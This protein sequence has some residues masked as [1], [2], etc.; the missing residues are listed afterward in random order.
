MTGDY[1]AVSS[2]IC[3]CACA[4]GLFGED[5]LQRAYRGDRAVLAYVAVHPGATAR[6]VARAISIPERIAVRSLDRLAD[7]G[8]L[9][10]AAD[11]ET[12]A[13]RSYQLAS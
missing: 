3:L 9:A 1:L 11:D 2:G 4:A 12:P 13:L 6:H 7:D 5:L 8:L 10:V